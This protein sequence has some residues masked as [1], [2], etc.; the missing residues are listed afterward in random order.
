MATHLGAP[1]TAAELGI[2]QARDLPRQQQATAKNW[3]ISPWNRWTFQRVQQ[4]TRTVRV[5]RPTHASSL[6][7]K[8]IYDFSELSFET[9]GKQSCTVKEMLSQTYTDAFLVIHKGEIISE[10]YFNGMLPDTLHLIMSCSKSFTSA[11]A[12]IVIDQGL[13]NPCK[14]VT[15][16]LPELSGSGFSDATLQQ[17]LDMRVGIKFSEDYDDCEADIFVQEVAAGWRPPELDYDGP[18]SNIAFAQGILSETAHGGTFRY[19]SIATDVVGLCIERVTGRNF[20][21]LFAEYIWQPMGAEYDLVSIVDTV[22]VASF[23]GG[24]NCSL[25]DFGRFGEMIMKGGEY[26]GEQIV[27]K[28]W[29]EKCRFASDDSMNAFADSDYGGLFPGGAYSNQWWIR[30]TQKGV[31][32]ALGVHGQTLYIDSVNEFVMAKFSSQPEMVDSEMFLNQIFG[33]EAI[34]SHISAVDIE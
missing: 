16:Y 28:E 10:Q 6:P 27:P 20:A 31:I 3:T 9:L 14:L 33:M 13:L 19:Q 1:P 18:L 34:V 23:Q 7:I 5:P 24:F 21:D 4:F 25:R 12:G 2:G 8:H 15:D 22:G 17:A 32:M 26:N 29:V 30:N 11:L